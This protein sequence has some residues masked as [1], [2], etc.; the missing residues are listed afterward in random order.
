MMGM[1]IPPRPRD[2]LEVPIEEGEQ[3]AA[4]EAA[5]LT[6]GPLAKVAAAA[7]AM[8]TTAGTYQGTGALKALVAGTY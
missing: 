4:A 8:E 3:A 7:A 2:P 5:G 1:G 6:T